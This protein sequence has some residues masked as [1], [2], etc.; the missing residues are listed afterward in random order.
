MLVQEIKVYNPGEKAAQLSLEKLGIYQWDDAT[1]K[2][3]VIAFWFTIGYA[4]SAWWKDSSK[5]SSM[6]ISIGSVVIEI[7]S[8][9]RKIYD[10]LIEIK[11]L[12][13]DSCKF[14]CIIIFISGGVRS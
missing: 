14:V 7:L 12:C 9:R 2:T 1:S 5:N 11:L 8:F 10:L 3:K 4:P 6:E 13:S